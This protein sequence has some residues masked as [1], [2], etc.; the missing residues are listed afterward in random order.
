MKGTNCSIAHTQLY[1][2]NKYS[3]YSIY[4]RITNK[5][6][7]YQKA[8]INNT[9][10]TVHPRPKL[11]FDNVED[12]IINFNNF[13]I[14]ARLPITVWSLVREFDKLAPETIKDN[15]HTKYTRVY[16]F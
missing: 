7:I 6:M 12:Q 5:D 1:F 11:K 15:V 4:K 14:K 16:R 2:H 3:F 13:N 8:G 9:K 10:L